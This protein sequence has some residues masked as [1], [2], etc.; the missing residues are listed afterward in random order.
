MGQK[1]NLCHINFFLF[2]SF[3]YLYLV[4]FGFVSQRF[5]DQAY[6][7]SNSRKKIPTGKAAKI[8]DL[9]CKFGSFQKKKTMCV[10]FIA[11]LW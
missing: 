5:T 6:Q 3:L 8:L 1:I 9:P 2:L 7:V 11:F 4:D 10:F